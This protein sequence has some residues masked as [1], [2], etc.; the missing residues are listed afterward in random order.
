MDFI[1]LNCVVGVCSFV[2]SFQWF[3]T[4]I[5]TVEIVVV[6]VSHITLDASIDYL[7]H[8]AVNINEAGGRGKYVMETTCNFCGFSCC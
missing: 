8:I 1:Q 3:E 5:Q 4:G 2:R 6:D 7:K